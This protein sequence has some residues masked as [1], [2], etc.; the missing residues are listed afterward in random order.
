MAI[1]PGIRA[2]GE[3]WIARSVSDQ[4]RDL[5]ETSAAIRN[6]FASITAAIPYVTSA[7]IT[8]SG[9]G[10]TD[11]QVIGS[12]TIPWVAGKR[13]CQVLVSADVQYIAAVST[14]YVPMVRCTIGGVDKGRFSR[15]FVAGSAYAAIGTRVAEITSGE[16]IQV[17]IISETFGQN[18]D[19]D[20]ANVCNAAVFAVF[21]N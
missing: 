1:P 3:D 5:R 17:N 8:T 11:G 18:I 21:T 2:S 15:L 20:D 6:S 13:L 14:A 12:A 4:A 19:A 10:M 16:T 7:T 9:W